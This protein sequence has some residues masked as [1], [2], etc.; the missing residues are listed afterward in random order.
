MKSGEVFSCSSGHAEQEAPAGEGITD[1]T[2]LVRLVM[3]AGKTEKIAS[4][5]AFFSF[6]YLFFYF[7][8]LKMCVLLYKQKT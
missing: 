8:Y 4:V 3:H 7:I 6:I 5:V 1:K 2:F